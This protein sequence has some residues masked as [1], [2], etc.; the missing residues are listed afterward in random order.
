MHLPYRSTALYEGMNY[1]AHIF[2]WLSTLLGVSSAFAQAPIQFTNSAE[3]VRR[4]EERTLEQLRERC[5]VQ[6]SAGLFGREEVLAL[7]HGYASAHG[8]AR[9]PNRYSVY[10]YDAEKRT[11]TLLDGQRLSRGVRL[12]VPLALPRDYAYCRIVRDS[13]GYEQLEVIHKALTATSDGQAFDRL[14]AD[15]TDLASATPSSCPTG[16]KNTLP[17]IDR[18]VLRGKQ[19]TFPICHDTAIS[20]RE[21]MDR[22]ARRVHER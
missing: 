8:Y 5:S 20:L 19:V 1:R 22:L 3:A 15:A 18:I 16:A 9:D 2:A 13:Q 7:R 12:T 4:Y 6:K 10:I 21:R 14:L 17:F 11:F